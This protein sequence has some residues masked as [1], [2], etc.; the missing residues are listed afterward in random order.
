MPLGRFLDEEHSQ[1]VREHVTRLT[2]AR[3]VGNTGL[4][5]AQPYLGV[6]GRSL[7]VSLSTMGIATSFGEFTGLLGPVVGHQLN[8]RS[9]RGSMTLA[10]CVLALGT[11]LAGAAPSVAAISIGFVVLSL[12]KIMFDNGMNSWLVERTE[13][14]TRG[15]VIGLTEIAWAG[16]ILVGIPL[17]AVLVFATSWRYAYGTVA[18]CLFFM[19]W[20]LWNHLPKDQPTVHAEGGRTA[21]VW[22]IPATAGF[23]SFGLVMAIGGCLFV[24]FGSW[25]KDVHGFSSLGIGAVSI[26]L[27]AVELIA[28]TSTIRFTDSWGK[29]RSIRV[30]VIIALPAAVGLAFVGHQ[31]A[32]GL[33]LLSVLFLGF[34]FAVVSFASLLPSLQPDSPSTAF[35]LA[36]G[37]GTVSRGIV[38][39]ASTR[40]YTAHGIGGSS[41]LA[42]S[43]AAA[44]LL[45]LT[46]VR[47]PA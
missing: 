36:V 8:K 31:A 23:L 5:F 39:I 19:A 32:L 25:L 10:L 46:F 6:I 14:A 47:E 12:G 44:A 33:I 4:R 42:A 16:A 30:G 15:R 13:Y 22:S 3:F 45:T 21:I 27:G 2:V 11:A 40:L 34:E 26:L 35:G 37:V 28:S 18:V 38:A 29:R 20:H 41:L 43:L 24:S 7:G 1:E 9:R 17:L